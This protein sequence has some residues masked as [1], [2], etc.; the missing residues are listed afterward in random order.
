MSSAF[1]SSA[2]RAAMRAFAVA[3]VACSPR[4]ARDATT[5]CDDCPATTSECKEIALSTRG[6]PRP[7]QETLPAL[8][9]DAPANLGGRHVDLRHVHVRDPPAGRVRLRLCRH[10]VDRPAR[11]ATA[12]RRSSARCQVASCAATSAP[13]ISQS[14]RSACAELLDGVDRVR[15][16]RTDRSRC[17]LLPVRPRR[18][19]RPRPSRSGRSQ[20]RRPNRASATDHRQRRREH[21]RA[22]S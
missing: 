14:S 3:S 15:R 6:S 10:R 20:A 13:R 11:G 8:P 5:S 7:E 12:A 1:L 19:P 21:G 22:S 9:R 17:G 2:A 4:L 16:A 18:Q